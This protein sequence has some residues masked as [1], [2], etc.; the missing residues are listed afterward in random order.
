MSILNSGSLMKSVGMNSIP[1]EEE[2][3]Q[4]EAGKGQDQQSLAQS[5]QNPQAAGD[6]DISDDEKDAKYIKSYMLKKRIQAKLNRRAQ[7]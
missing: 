3:E 6:D 5:L 4:V 7:G 2:E 1:E